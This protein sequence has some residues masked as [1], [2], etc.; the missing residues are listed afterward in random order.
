MA[1]IQ[2]HLARLEAQ[3]DPSAPRYVSGETHY[4][5]GNSYRLR[6][7][8]RDTR[9][10]VALHGGGRIEMVVPV[11]ADAAAR[12]RVLTEWYR[13]QLKEAMPALV[14]K[15]EPVVGVELAEWRVKRMRTRWGSC[16]VTARRIWVNLELVKR[17]V[18]CLE[19]VIVHEMVHLLERR[20][21]AR[22]RALMDR[23][24]PDWRTVREE[25]NRRPLSRLA[26]ERSMGPSSVP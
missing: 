2:R 19:Y 12:E 18:R 13:A 15:W 16:N 8:H 1:W 22:F 7:V 10:R 26:R 20:H 14:A 6:V 5:W 21:G 11:S 9:P 17:P 23:F 3:P 24:L 25:L 4:L